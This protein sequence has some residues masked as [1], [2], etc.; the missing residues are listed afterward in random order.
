MR[1]RRPPGFYLRSI[2]HRAA[3]AAERRGWGERVVS[4]VCPRCC[5][6]LTPRL[7]RD[8]PYFHCRCYEPK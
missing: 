4:G 7:A 5:G 2:H 1:R 8:R 3:D 6:R